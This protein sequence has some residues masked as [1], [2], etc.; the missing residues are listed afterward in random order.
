MDDFIPS[1]QTLVTNLNNLSIVPV[2]ERNIRAAF[3]CATWDDNNNNPILGKAIYTDRASVRVQHWTHV[4]QPQPGSDNSLAPR[5]RKLLLQQC[6]GCTSGTADTYCMYY[7]L[8]L[9]QP[10]PIPYT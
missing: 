5:S 9:L 8:T 6:T 10:V 7:Q 1:Q 4:T 2:P 3:W